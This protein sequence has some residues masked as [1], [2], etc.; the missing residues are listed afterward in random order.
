MKHRPPIL[1]VLAILCFAVAGIIVIVSLVALALE[2][3]VPCA[4]AALV[5]FGWLLFGVAMALDSA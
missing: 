3:C 2:G 4:V 1:G 5:V